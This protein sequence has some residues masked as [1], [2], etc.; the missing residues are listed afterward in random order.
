MTDDANLRHLADAFSPV[1]GLPC[2]QVRSGHGSFITLEF[3]EPSLSIREPRELATPVS[4]RVRRR[5]ARRRVTVRG[6]WHLWIYCCDWAVTVDDA[7]VG[8]SASDESINRAVVELDGQ[9]L[10]G[11]RRA[12]RPGGWRFDFDLGARLTTWPYDDAEQWCLY[13]PGDLVTVADATGQLSRGPST[14]M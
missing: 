2:W 7:V 13:E 14:E 4:E 6:Q 10:T 1:Y 8:D 3:G 9:K 5:L 12:P 11:V